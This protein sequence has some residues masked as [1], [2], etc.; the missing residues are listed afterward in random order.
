MNA[1]RCSKCKQEQ[2]VTE[3]TYTAST[4]DN[5]TSWCYSCRHAYYLSN[6]QR[7]LDNTRER[8]RPYRQ[9]MSNRARAKQ[10]DLPAPLTVDEWRSVLAQAEGRC[11]YCG[12]YVGADRLELDH[13]TPMIKGGPHSIENVAAAC[14]WCNLSKRHYDAPKSLPPKTHA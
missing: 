8:G 13:V 14:E 4:K 6:R 5:L 2:P 9:V 3:F 10:M 11:C 7:Y 1:K 12:S